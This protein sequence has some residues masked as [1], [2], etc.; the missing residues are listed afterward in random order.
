MKKITFSVFLSGV[1]L[2][3]WSQSNTVATGGDA[4]GTGGISQLF[5]GAN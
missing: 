5:C 4:T 2:I 3:S 1:T